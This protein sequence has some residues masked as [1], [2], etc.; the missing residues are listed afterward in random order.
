MYVS[1]VGARPNFIK[2]APIAKALRKKHVVVHT[3]QH[4]DYEMSQAFFDQMK[5]P[6]PDFN[7]GVGS[8]THAEQTALAMA[9]LEQVF[10]DLAPEVVITYG[11]VNSTLAAAVTA[12]KMQIPTAHVEAGLRSFDRTM[13]E[14]INRIVADHVSDILFAPSKVAMAQLKKEGLKGYFSGDVMYDVFLSR[15]NTPILKKEGLDDYYLAT[16]HR[17]AN[18][19]NEK[20]LCSIFDA[21]AALDKEVVLPLHPRTGKA[22]RA[23]GIKPK[24]V[25]LMPPVNYGDFT[26]LLVNADK[27]FTDS[28]GVQKEAFYAKTPC[29]TLRTTTEWPETLKANAN[30]LVGS[31]KKKIITAAKKKSKPNYKSKPYGDGHTAKKI[32]KYLGE[33]L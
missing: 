8:G 33:K 9:A 10:A 5:I 27:V 25:M 1:V 21:F 16:V 11:D 6:R 28:G 3:G 13:P 4:Y 22:M 26:T 7:L 19:D 18:T 24:N 30:V 17:P 20:A 2:L 31:N 32:V 15:K 12:A 14:E 29:V 23:Y